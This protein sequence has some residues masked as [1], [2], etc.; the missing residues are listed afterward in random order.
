MTT[1]GLLACAPMTFPRPI[2]PLALAALFTVG[3]G[4]GGKNRK[5]QYYGTDAG[6]VYVYSEAGVTDTAVRDAST[7]D[8]DAM[9][10]ASSDAPETGAGAA[11]NASP[12]VTPT[13]D[14]SGGTD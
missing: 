3:A 9:V 11:A 7:S 6:S 13:A 1:H 5:D 4:C 2:G 12:D 8:A 14:V 10:D